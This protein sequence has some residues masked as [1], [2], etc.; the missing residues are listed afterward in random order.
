M[1][2]FEKYHGAGNDFIMIDNRQLKLAH[3]D[4][5]RYAA[6]CDR[7]LGI[8]ADGLILLEEHPQAD[9][10]MVYFNS[11][12]Q[13]SSM[14]GNGARCT[15]SFAKSLGLAQRAG[16]LIAPDGLHT[17]SLRPNNDVTISMNCKAA[18]ERDGDAYVIDTGSPHY[19][20]FVEDVDAVDLISFAHSIRYSERYREVGINVNIVEH[21]SSLRMRT[22]ERGVED[23]TLA[24]GT[25]VTAAALIATFLSPD[26]KSKWQIE[27][28]GGLLSVECTYDGK[29]F[30]DVL[31]TGP[32]CKVFEG[33]I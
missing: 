20:R 29:Q 24:C 11:D 6:W 30:T 2:K 13:L 21:G 3:D 4:Q 9:F 26:Q 10:E 22:Y 12:G 8:G 28:R 18:I 7:H 5:E 25:G 32:T 19:V 33:S 14:C 17:Y 16:T 31:L 23:E 1:I 27:T 15:V